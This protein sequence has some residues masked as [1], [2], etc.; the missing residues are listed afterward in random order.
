LFVPYS[1]AKLQ[2]FFHICKK[3]RSKIVFFFLFVQKAPKC[4]PHFFLKAVSDGK[5]ASKGEIAISQKKPKEEQVVYN[6]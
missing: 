5:Y 3:K 1:A 2:L 4:S 6:T